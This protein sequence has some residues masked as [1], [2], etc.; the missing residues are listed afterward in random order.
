[1]SVPSFQTVKRFQCFDSFC[2]SQGWVSLIMSC[3]SSFSNSK[4]IK[5]CC[6]EKQQFL[7][8]IIHRSKAQTRRKNQ[9]SVFF[10]MKASLPAN[11]G[12]IWREKKRPKPSTQVAILLLNLSLWFCSTRIDVLIVV[13]IHLGSLKSCYLDM[14]WLACTC[15]LSLTS[16]K[17]TLKTITVNLFLGGVSQII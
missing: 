8:G 14:I 6:Q 11:F 2:Q 5:R 3:I 9:Y 10:Y 13:T 17:M 15:V 1:M 16:T 12:Q 4:G 7:H